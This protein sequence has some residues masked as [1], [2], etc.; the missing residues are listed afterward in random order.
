MEQLALVW[1]N[2]ESLQTAVAEIVRLVND[3]LAGEE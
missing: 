2:E 1:R 3:I